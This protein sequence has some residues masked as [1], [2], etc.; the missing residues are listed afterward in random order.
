MNKL[1]E[2]LRPLVRV[3]YAWDLRIARWF[4]T[5]HSLSGYAYKLELGGRAVGVWSVNRIDGA[6]QF[7]WG[8]RDHCKTAYEK[9]IARKGEAS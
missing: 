7:W 1:R 3:L 5:W 8:Q 4:G 2:L 9:E 6:F